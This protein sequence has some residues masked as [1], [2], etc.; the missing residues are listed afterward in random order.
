MTSGSRPSDAPRPPLEQDAAGRD[1]A[2]P[3]RADP[4]VR[5][6]RSEGKQRPSTPPNIR[7]TW[8]W[9]GVAFLG[10]LLAMAWL[11]TN[12]DRFWPASMERGD[13]GSISRPPAP[14]VVQTAQGGRGVDP[15][16]GRGAGPSPAVD[17]RLGALGTLAALRVEMDG[18]ETRL[19]AV[20]AAADGAAADSS[21][22]EAILLAF[23]ARRTL[24]RGVPLGFLQAQLRQR[25]PGQ[26]RAVDAVVAAAADPVTVESLH[27][28]LPALARSR[29]ERFG[30]LFATLSG[31]GR[32]L[33]RLVRGDAD[34]G[35]V[36]TRLE[37]ARSALARGDVDA[38]ATL[39]AGLP[40]TRERAEWLRSAGRYLAAHQALD[41]IETAAILQGAGSAGSTP[42]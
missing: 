37:D 6:T 3:G 1:P 4:R 17:T 30:G 13:A 34:R 35:D 2:A 41:V 33:F 23:A 38:A 5:P 21:R 14:E 8:I 15:V 27:A 24:D 22:A 36:R 28:A 9:V 25:F 12:G 18:L 32:P 7:S 39:V 10:G 42:R 29:T 40:T 19:A 20:R 16:T 11:L 31:E 26:P